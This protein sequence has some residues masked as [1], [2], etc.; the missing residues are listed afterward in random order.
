M[1]SLPGGRFAPPAGEPKATRTVG[2]YCRVSSD[3][4]AEAETIEVQRDFLR[5]YC[6]LHDLEIAGEYLD[7]GVRGTVPFAQRP[8]GARLL[9]DARLG[10]FDTV[11]FMRV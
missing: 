7:D 5:R 4:Q 3:E 10:R 2:V 1:S 8:A 11:L 6:E 9:D